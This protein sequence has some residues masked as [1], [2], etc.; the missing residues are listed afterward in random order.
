MA[1]SQII[2]C[3]VCMEPVAFSGRSF[4]TSRWRS[5]P[6]GM[7]STPETAVQESSWRRAR[8]LTAQQL[9]K[10]TLHSVDSLLSRQHC[11]TFDIAWYWPKRAPL[12]ATTSIKVMTNAM[13][14]CLCEYFNKVF[15]Y[16]PA[17]NWVIQFYG[18]RS[19]VCKHQNAFI[20]IFLLVFFC[21][22]L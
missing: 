12:G 4:G 13:P 6:Y 3:L 14:L 7:S 17:R 9:P 10:S 20:R 22:K 19:D 21:Y 1:T 16:L 18:S 11:I 15:C 5:S 2:N 8:T